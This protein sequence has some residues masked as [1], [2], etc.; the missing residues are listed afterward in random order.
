MLGEAEQIYS[1]T[2]PFTDI[3]LDDDTDPFGAADIEVAAAAAPAAVPA[4][5]PEPP[6]RGQPPT[7]GVQQQV[8][9]D[10]E[11]EPRLKLDEATRRAIEQEANRFSEKDERVRERRKAPKPAEETGVT[12]LFGIPKSIKPTRM[13]GTKEGTPFLLVLATILLIL[14]NLGAAALLVNQ[15]LLPM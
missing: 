14:L 10:A 7:R 3:S 5:P 4:A 2:S 1:N 15:I 6:S 13:P 8:E 11:N 12:E 9:D